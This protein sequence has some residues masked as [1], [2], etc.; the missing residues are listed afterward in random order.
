MPR[1]K[2]HSVVLTFDSTHD[3]LAAE[4]FAAAHALAGRLIPVPV[5]ISAGCG[6]AFKMD[7][8]A[9]PTFD[10]AAAGK[11]AWAGRYEMEL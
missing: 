5:E 8:A 6:L 4:K 9:W 3:A 11:L 7:A 10:A 2:K 1:Q